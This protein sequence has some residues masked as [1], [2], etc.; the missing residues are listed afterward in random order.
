MNYSFQ[1]CIVTNHPFSH[2]WI[3]ILK[4]RNITFFLIHQNKY[5]PDLRKFALYIWYVV[6]RCEHLKTGRGLCPVFECPHIHIVNGKLPYM[7]Q[8]YQ[9]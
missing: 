6:L 4:N 9:V 2:C 5:G 8:S 3:L 7:A 1:L